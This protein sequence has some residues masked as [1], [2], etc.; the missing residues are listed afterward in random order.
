MSITPYL[1]TL[2]IAVGVG[3]T[4]SATSQIAR[5][6]SGQLPPPNQC[7]LDTVL[8]LTP[9]PDE[10]EWHQPAKLEWSAIVPANCSNVQLSLDG[11]SVANTGTRTVIPQRRTTF[12]LVASEQRGSVFSYKEATAEIR[13]RY[14]KLVSIELNTPDAADVLIG[15]LEPVT[16][17][18][19]PET[20]CKAAGGVW[21]AKA[22]TC[23]G[24]PVVVEL[25]CNVAL[26]MT[27]K[28]NVLIA[29]NR[30]LVAKRGC[31]RS[32]VRLGPRIFVRDERKRLPLFK[33]V[34]DNVEVSGFRL[35]GP[36]NYMAQG[37]RKEKGIV[38]NTPKLI[39]PPDTRPLIRHIVVSNM[40]IYYWSGLGVQVTDSWSTEK[41]LGLLNN[42]TVGAVRVRDNYLHHN[43]HG[44]GEGYGI[45]VSDGAYALI[46]RNVFDENRHAI[47]G[48]SKGD[49]KKDADGN[50]IEASV[51]YSG[52]TVRDNLILP[53]GGLHC[54]DG[55]EAKWGLGIGAALGAAIGGLLGGPPG[56]VVGGLAG[57][58]LL[59]AAG[60]II[61]GFCWQ[62]HLID[63]HGDRNKSYSDSNWQC[64]TAGETLIIERNTILYTKGTA[65]K[66]R[67]NPADKA[68][69]DGNVFK[70][71]REGSLIVGP[72]PF[73]TY[74][75]I[76][77][78][79][80]CD[81][82]GS[83]TSNPIQISSTN[84]FNRDPMQ[85][86]ASCNLGSGGQDQFM[87]TGATWWAKSAVTGQWYYLNTMPEMV[88]QLHIA[89]FDGDGICDVARE[90]NPR[91]QLYSKSGRT[92]WMLI[93][94]VDVGPVTDE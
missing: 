47:A 1:V 82:I 59:G 7:I 93:G 83:D 28:V 66:I 46:E 43:R 27:A 88:L 90:I 74:P 34:G 63:M 94:A 2:L 50:I 77:Q 72:F 51:D 30:N 17:R 80:D 67:G 79:G 92:P 11:Q 86:L 56:A 71:S 19:L 53:G 32:M 18:S 20:D 65:I 24:L 68:V 16:F 54:R 6:N 35:Q 91:Q 25:G 39:E 42:Q 73:F 40:D 49:D 31:E 87:A 9:A 58:T 75:T 26:D 44:A 70:S 29:S 3:S 61:Q 52:Y 14:P 22:N 64:G 48:G 85:Q 5:D 78:T 45:D 36:T 60:A 38:I 62:T 84:A 69:V 41:R 89:D 21:D 33:I 8:T 81:L 76:D 37:D 23:T 55:N 57:A 12:R 4:V 13:V 15:A 10:V